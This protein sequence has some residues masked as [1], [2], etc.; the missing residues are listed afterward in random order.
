VAGHLYIH[1][2]FCAHRCGYC[3]FV[4][5]AAQPELHG[6]YVDALTR[7]HAMRAGAGVEYDT[8]FI[9]GGTPTLLQLESLSALVEW[10]ASVAGGDAEITIEANPETVTPEL[11]SL[12]AGS[13]V[14]RV[15]LGAQSLQPHVLAALERRAG[16]EV[17]VNAFHELRSA[18][19]SNIGLD[20]LWGVPGQTSEQLE[21]D[22]HAIAELGPDH[23]SAYELEFKPGSRI[24]KTLGAD[25]D[26]VDDSG[27][28]DDHYDIVIDALTDA[29]YEWYETANFARGGKVARHNL[30]YWQLH[31]Y[32]G[33]GVGAVGTISGQRR[34][35]LPNLVN[36]LAAIEGG[37]DA[38]FRVEAI[39]ADTRAVERVMLGLRLARP[40]DLGPDE[41]GGV[42]DPDAL[43]RME[44]ME[45]LTANGGQ[46]V[47]SRRGRLL[48]SGVLTELLA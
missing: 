23:I 44:R 18:E 36:Y 17:V 16:P 31:D 43:A 15:S 38:P 40:F 32:L 22:L 10:V 24:A 35:N 8:V 4:T 30:A 41:P 26:R 33:I 25:H 3:T 48:L 1:V 29:G 39:D 14:N 45:L 46:I 11:A 28:S 21:D 13:C 6:R 27:P 2:P 19:I 5:T 20:L 7:E 37:A 34:T 42:I 47:L 12:L 9:G